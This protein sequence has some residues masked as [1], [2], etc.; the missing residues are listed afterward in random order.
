[1]KVKKM[2]NKRPFVKP[3]IFSGLTTE[4]IDS[5]LNK[6]DRA[7][8][9]NGWTIE[10]KAKY[11]VEFLEGPALTFYANSQANNPNT[12][13]WEDIEKNIRTEFEPIAHKNV[14]RSMLK[15]RKQLDD[16]PTVVYIY[17]IESLCKRVDRLMSQKEMVR[18]MMKGLRPNIARYIGMLENSTVNELKTNIR[19]HENLEFVKTGTTYQS[20]SEIKE[21]VFNEQLNSLFTHLNEKINILNDDNKKLKQELKNT[22]TKTQRYNE[23][24][25]NIPLYIPPR[26]LNYTQ[27]NT[28]YISQQILNNPQPQANTNYNSRQY[29]NNSLKPQYELCSKYGYIKEICRSNKMNQNEYN[30]VICQLCDKVGHSAPACFLYFPNQTEL[31]NR[32]NGYNDELGSPY[33]SKTDNKIISHQI[34]IIN[35][36][37]H[38]EAY[39]ENIKMLLTIDTGSNI[40]CIRHT[41]VPN[42]RIIKKVPIILTGANNEP[43][44]VLGSTVV[45]ITIETHKFAITSYVVKNLSCG[46]ILGNE[47]FFKQKA[48]INFVNETITLNDTLTIKTYI[49]YTKNHQVNKIKEKVIDLFAVHSTYSIAHCI[50]ADFKMSKG[51][52][53]HIKKKFGDASPQLSKLMPK[54]GEAIP[55]NMGNRIIYYLIT[56][57]RY[58]DKPVYKNIKTALQSLHRTMNHLHDYKLAIPTIAS[59]IDKQ[60]WSVIKQIIFSEFKYSKIKLLI[61]YKSMNQITNSW[62]TREHVQIINLIQDHY[63]FK[64]ITKDSSNITDTCYESNTNVQH[65]NYNV[66]STQI[67]NNSDYNYIIDPDN[68]EDDEINIVFNNYCPGENVQGD[69]NCGLYA[70]CNALNDNKETQITS[71]D[72]LLELLNLSKLPGHWW[73][74]EELASIA[75]YYNHDTYIFDENTTTGIIYRNK[76]FNRPPVILYNSFNNT[77]WIPGTRSAELSLKIPYNYFEINGIIPLKQI[78][79]KLNNKYYA[80]SIPPIKNDELEYFG[81]IQITFN[82]NNNGKFI[83]INSN[84][85]NNTELL[86]CNKSTQV[87]IPHKLNPSK[88]KYIIKLLKNIYTFIYFRYI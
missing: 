13:K 18:N 54:V 78:I 37:L 77:H 47:F 58:F 81:Q 38:I 64:Q 43:L 6:Y 33:L 69:G 45:N 52:A 87:S 36:S 3:A 59:G 84:V 79:A 65:N 35:E 53:V 72:Q 30:T 2:K 19:K 24:H 34:N 8:E 1:M 83:S 68:Y 80:G 60:N 16:E 63:N 67:C 31:V 56:K 57:Q 85:T 88:Y 20:S 50:S 82:N 39:L 44:I 61:C 7:A 11:F 75:D 29:F 27:P 10:E 22:K 14:I 25:N 23:Y 49:N 74:D 66:N 46:F 42:N 5:F 26:Q 76:D 32:S 55:I 4:N 73:S 70:L 12:P 9:I 51:L 71:I 41:L 48:R 17:E 62:K 15:K 21:Y 28:D 40:C 86:Q